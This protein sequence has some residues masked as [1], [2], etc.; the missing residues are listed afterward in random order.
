MSGWFSATRDGETLKIVGKGFGHG[1]GLCQYGA[2]AMGEA[3]V[4]A[5]SRI[6]QVLLP[7]RDHQDGVVM[8]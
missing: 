8:A 4:R 2:A 6:I 3:H 5:C 1:A 7:G